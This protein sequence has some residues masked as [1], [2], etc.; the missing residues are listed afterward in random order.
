MVRDEG[1]ARRKSNEGE[2]RSLAIRRSGLPSGEPMTV[3][4]ESKGVTL[5]VT[6]FCGKDGGRER[7]QIEKKVCQL[8]ACQVTCSNARPYCGTQVCTQLHHQDKACLPPQ[9]LNK[10]EI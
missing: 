1:D 6:P 10:R 5:P 7:G 4:N 9:G 8:K 2:S 3:L